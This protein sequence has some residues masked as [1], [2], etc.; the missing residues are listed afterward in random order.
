MIYLRLH[1]QWVGMR[2]D[3]FQIPGLE[4]RGCLLSLYCWLWCQLLWAPHSGQCSAHDPGLWALG[5]AAQEDKRNSAREGRDSLFAR[6]PAEVQRGPG[7]DSPGVSQGVH[8]GPDQRCLWFCSPRISTC[9]RCS[10]PM[11]TLPR[12][13]AASHPPRLHPAGSR[14]KQVLIWKLP[15]RY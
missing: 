7:S 12:A 15:G 9:P 14:E 2:G 8:S 11:E 10:P 6:G 5:T 13:L 1:W 3:S 4:L